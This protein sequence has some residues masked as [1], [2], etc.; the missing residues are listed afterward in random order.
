MKNSNDSRRDF[1]R[2]LSYLAAGGTAAAFVPQLRMLNSALASPLAIDSLSGYRALV[3]VYLA[4]GNDSWNMLVPYESSRYGI[5]KD[6]RGGDATSSLAIP[7]QNLLQLTGAASSGS[8]DYALHPQASLLR[9]RYNAQQLAFV[10]NTGTLTKPIT[11]AQYSDSANRPPQLFSHSDQENL[12]HVGTSADNKLGWGG[13]SIDK[14]LPQFP[15]GNN[16]SLSPA[17]SVAG[18]NKFQIGSSKLPYQMSTSGVSGMQGVCNPTPCTGFSGQRDNAFNHL[19]NDVPY[20]GNTMGSEYRNVVK[21]GRGLYDLINSGLSSANGNTDGTITTAFPAN[22][23]LG[24]QLK[25]VA[26]MIKLSRT[27]SLAAR[28]VYYVRYGGFDLHDGLLNGHQTLLTNLSNAMDKFWTAMG[29]IGAQSDVTA[30]TMSEFARTLSSNGDGSDHA[31]GGVQMVMGG[32]VKGG[33]LYADGGIPG[34]NAFPDQTLNGPVSFTRGQFIPG[35]SVDQYTATLA[36][37][38]GLPDGQLDAIFP[39]LAAFNQSYRDLGFLNA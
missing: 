39:N 18:N 2:K 37:W 15:V 13:Q 4:G 33:K 16:A 11:K 32:A 24:D 30:F 9:D 21:S 12:W 3:C 19:L 7:R 38:L 36:K 29:E 34:N 31:W 20:T 8:T 28:Q 10:V 35:I 14:L 6:S 23:S 22:N 25:M 17:I 5:Y 1:L 27:R 26:R